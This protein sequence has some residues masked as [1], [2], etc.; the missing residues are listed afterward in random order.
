MLRQICKFLEYYY[1]DMPETIN[2]ECLIHILNIV[3][4]INKETSLPIII[5]WCLTHPEIEFLTVYGQ[6]N[7]T[8]RERPVY[9]F[10]LQ[11]SILMRKR[12]HKPK[13]TV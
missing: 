3:F 7:S 4:D 6:I 5:D 8:D 12:N 10:D 1:I 11:E 13:T 9:A 2:L